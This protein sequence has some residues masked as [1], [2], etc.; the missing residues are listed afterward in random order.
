MLFRWDTIGKVFQG[1]TQI[2]K[3]NEF[4]QF[5]RVSSVPNDSFNG[6]Y[7]TEI[8]LPSQITSIGSYAFKNAHIR[9]LTVP[10]GVTQILSQGFSTG[11]LTKVTMLGTTP[12]SITSNNFSNSRYFYVPASALDTYK[13]ASVW[14]SYASYILPIPE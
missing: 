2:R 6:A 5:T 9:E 12:P 4:V 1:N 13:S 10:A 14:S 8:T 3:F 7:L 11:Y